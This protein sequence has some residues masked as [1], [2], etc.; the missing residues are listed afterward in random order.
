MRRCASCGRSM[1]DEEDFCKNCGSGTTFDSSDKYEENRNKYYGRQFEDPKPISNIAENNANLYNTPDIKINWR[2]CGMG[3]LAFIGLII[4]LILWSCG[5]FTPNKTFKGDGY[6]ITYNKNWKEDSIDGSKA[7]KYDGEKSYLIPTE[8]EDLSSYVDCDFA[9]KDCKEELFDIM[10]D[11]LYK[12]DKSLY[13]AKN[14]SFSNLKD[15]IYYATYSII[16]SDNDI[17]GN[18]FVVVS[19]DSEYVITFKS[20]TSSKKVKSFNKKVIELL[21]GI[22]FTK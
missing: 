20:S 17:I 3:C 15:D 11:Y 18:Y 9:K 8:A 6:K 5:V 16:D 1:R 10:S 7:L 2:G 13:V 21:D 22:E 14:N 19:K 12:Q 4:L